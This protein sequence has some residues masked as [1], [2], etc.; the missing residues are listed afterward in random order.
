[1]Q[2]DFKVIE[3]HSAQAPFYKYR[4]PY[5]SGLFEGIIT[6]LGLDDQSVL[7]DACCG[8]GEL[9]ARLIER[10]GHIHAFDGSQEMLNHAFPHD[11][12]SYS[13]CDVNVDRFRAPQPVNHILIGRALHWIERDS[14]QQL[15]EDNLADDGCVLICSSAW[16]PTGPWEMPYVRLLKRYCKNEKPAA[17]QFNGAEKMENA[18]FRLRDRIVCKADMRVSLRYLFGHTLS[19]AYGEDFD[20]LMANRKDFANNLVGSLSPFLVDGKLSQKTTSYAAI[21]E[22]V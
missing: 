22:R 15:V 9:S 19:A 6:E 3:S 13:L 1:M 11:R 8:R 21:Y 16:T 2:S 5:L 14:L 10:V 4:T 17:A 18:G 20:R 12:I 7:V